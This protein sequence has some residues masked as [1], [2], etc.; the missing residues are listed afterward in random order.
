MVIISEQNIINTYNERQ[1]IQCKLYSECKRIKQENPNYGYKRISKL[2]HQ[3]YPKTRWWHS[4]KHLPVPI[5]TSN[6][7]KEKG[8]TPLAIDNINLPA[9]A[10]VL[11]ATFGDGGIFSNLN[12]IFLSSSEKEAVKDFGEDI[13]TIF[14]NEIPQN[15]RIIEGGVYGHSWCYQNTNRNVIRFFQ[16]LGAP[17]GKKSNI[18]L[19]TP[20]W[21][22]HNQEAQDAFYSAFFSNEIG[23]PKIH[24]Q[25]K[26]ANSLDLSLV[27]KKELKNN[28]IDFLKG[29][30]EY[31]KS[32]S[33][34]A[35]SIY[36]RPHKGD[37]S[38][39]IIKLAI[40]LDF[41]NL[42]TFY[43]NIN[44]SY[45]RHKQEKLKETLNQLT[46]LKLQRFK[47]LSNTLNTLTK[48]NYSEE[49]LKHNLKLTGKSLK[50][51]L[52]KEPIEKWN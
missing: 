12:G 50:F 10:R 22:K 36:I 28:R 20:T 3:S 41:D 24:I 40:S 34:K 39:Y 13:K 49:W 46:Q 51:I 25:G 21:L 23:I 7:L 33:I 48:R 47:K 37:E 26:G 43:R 2:L 42:M 38:S 4:R 19:T 15:S 8:L 16:A 52:K 35:A 1:Q 9:I 5:Q 6:W 32:K 29:I 31:L 27:C 18:K 14:G 44:L 11:G 17:I 45:S 30:Q